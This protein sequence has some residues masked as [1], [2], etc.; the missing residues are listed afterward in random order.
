MIVDWL[1][2]IAG[3]ALLVGG[4]EALVR[5]ASGI[6]LLAKVTPAVVGLTIVAA[7]T[8]MPELVVS[9]QSA[10]EGS[11]GIAVGNVVGSNIFNIAAILGLTA[12]V[13]PLRTQGNTVRL[14]WPVMMLAAFQFHLLARD[15]SV[16]RLEG[17]FLFTALVAFIAYAVWLGRK[18]ATQVEKEGFE[19]LATAS[20]GRTGNTAV[21]FNIVAVILGVGLLA[22]GSTA[23]V[24]GAVGVASALGVSDA[25]IGLTIVA[26]GTST[27][28][29]VTSIVAA[30]RGRD[31]IAVANVVGSNIFNVLGIAGTTAL[32][33]PLP[34][35]AEILARDNWWMLGASLLLFP[36]MKTGMR[37]NRVE[38]AILFVGFAAYMALL[39]LVS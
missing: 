37:V 8:S 36:L 9:L 22:G 33:H 31:D 25:V 4:G 39:V 19:E 14:E 1:L 13:R 3:L 35:P 11:P 15:G 26:A 24:R 18:S 21:T 10:I 28:E 17:G 38:G 5:G 27:P 32:V 29:L 6:A 23:L 2:I 20:F 30:W 7:G 16:D 12:L 34:V